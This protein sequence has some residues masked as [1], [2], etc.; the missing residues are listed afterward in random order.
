MNNYS[1]LSRWN[2]TSNDWKVAE[3]LRPLVVDLVWKRG[4]STVFQ[5]ASFV[6]YIGVITGVKPGAFSLTINER[7][8]WNGGYVGLLE[9]IM[10]GDH[11]QK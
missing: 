9:W 10:F 5:S 8:S 6:G 7:F 11:D 1:F 2:A 3:K 4:N